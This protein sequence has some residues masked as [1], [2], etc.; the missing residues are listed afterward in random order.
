MNLKTVKVS[1]LEDSSMEKTLHEARHILGETGYTEDSRKTTMN[2]KDIKYNIG[3]HWVDNH[4]EVSSDI[5]DQ[6]YSV[7][8]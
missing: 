4:F 3:Y 5:P 7:L 1:D 6:N 8:S 2:I